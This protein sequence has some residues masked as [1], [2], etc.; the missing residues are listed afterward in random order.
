MLKLYIVSSIATYC[1]GWSMMLLW[2]TGNYCKIQIEEC[3]KQITQY[4]K[5]NLEFTTLGRSISLKTIAISIIW[6]T[7]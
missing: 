4:K 6:F 3:Y 5:S 7:E 1:F 2:E